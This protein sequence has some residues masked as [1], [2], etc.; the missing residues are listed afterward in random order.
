MAVSLPTFTGMALDR[1]DLERKDPEWVRRQLEHPRARVV[2]AAKDEVLLADGGAAPSVA[3]LAPDRLAPDRAGPPLL[4]GLES[5]AP[6]FAADLDGSGA[7]DAQYGSGALAAQYRG[8]ALAAQ[9]G[10]GAPVPPHEAR[11]P[12]A[13]RLASL[14]DAGALLPAP[15]AGLAAYAVALLNW[16]RRHG[17]CANCG[18]PTAVADAGYSRHCPRCGAHHFPRVDPVVI[19]LV[20]R[21]D[22]LL[23]GRQPTWPEGRYSALA[24][25]VA[26][27]EAAEEAV[28][29]E[30][31]EEARVEA[32]EPQFV[33]SQP[34]PFPG[35]LML[36]FHATATGGAE[37][38][39]ADGELEAVRW[40]PRSALERAAAGD[41]AAG[42][43][44]PPPIAIA[45]FL[46]DRWLAR[47]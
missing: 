36:G 34:W 37:P 29:R 30:V 23:L 35:S 13:T 14:R 31:R 5:G 38:A 44:L 11:A 20:S 8:G 12:D 10:G 15:E 9:Y 19:M 26:P 16:H 45:R 39:P 33:A 32:R 42:L 47:R 22:E 18:A 28:I 2:G 7:P 46:V 3:R 6:V 41:P 1:A 40:F 24:G 21:D 43:L 27:G 25:F 17:F 4:L